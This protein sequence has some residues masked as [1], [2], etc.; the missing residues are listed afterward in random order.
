M[1]KTSVS[2]LD[3][4]VDKDARAWDQ[5]VSLYTPLIQAWLRRQAAPTSD[6]Q[7]LVQEVLT[8]VLRRLP[9]F[10]HNGRP[11]AFRA[12]LRSITV[13]CLREF[14]R[15]KRLRPLAS[16]GSD[17]Q[18]WLDQLSD[19]SSVLSRLWD[20]EHDVH[21]MKRLLERIEPEFAASTWQAFRR[22]GLE[23]AEPEV[24]AREVGIS[25]NAVFIAKSRV[26]AR[27]R[28]EAQGLVDE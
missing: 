25:V 28:Q 2:L 14:W 12:W 3:R 26:L 11:G 7:D 8:V 6:D 27:L 18:Q 5:L 16:G 13:N 21:V 4:L 23:G 22:V 10:E 17:F 20:R 9:E 15:S 19:S 24:V 1:D